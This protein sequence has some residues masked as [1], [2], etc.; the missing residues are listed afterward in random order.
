ML[1]AVPTP[2]T[3]L[4]LL[5]SAIIVPVAFIVQ[6]RYG[7][8]RD[9][10]CGRNVG[11][12]QL[13]AML[14]KGSMGEVWRARHRLLA[15]QAA[16]KLFCP[17]MVNAAQGGRTAVLRR[18]FEIE[19]QV[20]A[21]LRSP[22]T[23]ELYD[24][25]IAEDG[26]FFYAMELLDG[27]DLETLVRRF[28]PQP[29]ARVIHILRHCCESLAEAHQRG[30]VHRDIKPPNLFACRLAL[31]YDFIKVLDFGLVKQTSN[32]SETRLTMDGTATGTPGYMPPEVALGKRCVDGRAD[33]YA[34]G[35]VAYWLLTGSMVFEER[36][37]VAMAI[38]HVHQRPKLPS[39]RAAQPVPADLDRLILRCLEKDPEKRP[40]SAKELGIELSAL[41]SELPWSSADAERWW[42]ENFAAEPTYHDVDATATVDTLPLTV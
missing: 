30:M 22:H 1:I 5:A 35:C 18:R 41:A 31:S 17:E 19:A 10:Y 16:V 12:Y 4:T 9:S 7:V 27:V 8:E 20:T 39:A 21:S 25:G 29:A 13:E 24:F 40:Q 38:A 14:G 28:G 26:S 42:M 3:V 34:L 6:R 23:V 33:L 2:L 15:R 11:S 32:V 37:A 36:S